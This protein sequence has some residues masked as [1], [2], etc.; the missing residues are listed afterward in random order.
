MKVI[1]RSY[2]RT[3]SKMSLEV[4]TRLVN[5]AM[6]WRGQG[7]GWGQMERGRGRGQLFQGRGQGQ[8]FWPRGWGLNEDLIRQTCIQ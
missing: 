4:R 3:R 1:G 5:E 6:S 2:V 7:R 8:V